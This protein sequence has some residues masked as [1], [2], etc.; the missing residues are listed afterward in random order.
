MTTDSSHVLPPRWA[1]ATLRLL[2]SPNDRDSVSGDLLE[3]YRVSIVPEHGGAAPR[4]YVRQVAGFLLRASWFWG[5]A[6]GATLIVRYLLDTLAPV[7]YVAGV[8]HPRSQI[9]SQALIAT[10]AFAAAWHTWRTTY[11][12]TGVLIALAAALIGGAMSSAGAGVMLAIWHDPQTMTAWRMSGGLDE[13]LI[14]VPLE[15]IPISLISG[16]LGAVAAKGLG[17]PFRRRSPL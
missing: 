7:Q 11:I 8:I 10:F 2:L 17:R 5:T 1:E 13:A 14:D 16:L 15:M 6:V 4:W 9:M 12:R 3:E